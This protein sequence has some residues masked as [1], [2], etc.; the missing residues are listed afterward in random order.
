[1]NYK[2]RFME[3][4]IEAGVLT[5][6]D[7][8]TKSGRKTPYFVNTG[9]YKTGEQIGKLGGFYADCIIEN[10]KAGT[11]AE[12]VC[13]LFGP[14]YKGIPLSVATSIALSS[15]YGKNLNYCF[16]R[17]EIKDHG[18]GGSMVGYRLQ[19][20]DKVLIIEDVITA[21]TAV[22][23][24]IPLLKAAADV[25]IAGLVISVDRMERGQGELSAIQEIKEEF[26][27]ETYPI[28]TVR[29]LIDTLYMKEVN[30]KVVI[31]ETMRAR[32]EAYLEEYCVK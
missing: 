12:D 28:V 30:G 8:T 5:F 4:M 18:E 9:N 24:S 11:L 32:M 27:I 20:G 6:G 3:L 26:G 15:A 25:E 10:Q 22:R 16:N 2:E 31:D 7:F 1:M 14:A 19:D 13:A 21:G 29:E 23:E 17:K